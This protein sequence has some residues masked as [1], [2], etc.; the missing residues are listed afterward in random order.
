M[1]FATASTSTTWV[2]LV[3][4]DREHPGRHG[5]DL[6][7]PRLTDAYGGNFG[8]DIWNDSG[9]RGPLAEG[10]PVAPAKLQRTRPKDHY[11]H[12]ETFHYHESEHRKEDR[13]L[14]AAYQQRVTAAQ[15]PIQRSADIRERG[16]TPRGAAAGSD[17]AW[18]NWNPDQG[19]SWEDHWRDDRSRSRHS[20]GWWMGS[21]WGGWRW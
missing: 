4:S 9:T 3:R 10:M 2:D 18:G 20:S 13:R 1:P 11:V 17:D 14:R 5:P 21:G 6:H 7:G 12:E 15:A 8:E 19:A 16:S